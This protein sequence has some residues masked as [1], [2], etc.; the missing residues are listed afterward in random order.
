MLLILAFLTYL[1]HPLMDMDKEERIA[2]DPKTGLEKWI[3]TQTDIDFSRWYSSRIV[4]S[5]PWLPLGYKT[6]FCSVSNIDMF[7]EKLAQSTTAKK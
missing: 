5:W 6:G 2:L 7:P 3:V 1:E 4:L